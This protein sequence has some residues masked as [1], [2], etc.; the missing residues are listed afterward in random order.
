MN[1]SLRNRNVVVVACC[2]GLLLG[3]ATARADYIDHFATRTDVGLYKVPS[4]GPTR[5]LVL[6][7]FIDDIGYPGGSE[8]A[9]LDEI[10]AFFADGADAIF[11]G[12]F[13]FTPYWEQASLGRFRP[14]AEVAAP[15][16]FPTC[17]PLGAHADCEIPRGAG[18]AEGDIQGAVQVLQDALNF[19]DEI[20]TCA[21]AGPGG[22]SACTAGGGVDF[23]RYDTSGN[24]QGVADGFVDGVI[25]VS[26]A[27]F[28]GIAL[29][30]KDLATNPLLS[31]FGPFPSFTYPDDDGVVVASVGIAGRT[32]RP[33]RE[34][35]VSVHEF[36][37]LLGFC[38]L[39]NES[40]A[41]TDHPYTLMGGWFYADAGS[42]L[43]PFSRVAIGWANVIQVA[44]P[45]QAFAVPSA[46]RSGTVL[47]VGDGD[48][49][50]LVE[51]R[52]RL[53]DV[54]DADMSID[55][56]VLVQRVRLSKRPSP[57]P[58]DY[59]N[60]LQACVNCTP[61]DAMLTVE[62]ADGNYD[63]QLNRG[64]DDDGDLFQSGD[65][66]GPSTD[67]QQR[68][69]NHVVF[70][71]NL[72]SGAPTGL[73][74]TVT[75]SDDDGAVVDVDA[76][77]VADPCAALSAVCPG[78]CVVD[79]DG[80]GRCG[81]FQTFPATPPEDDLPPPVI[82]ACTCANTSGADAGLLAAGLLLLL[83]RRQRAA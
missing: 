71:T 35:F 70:S 43:D 22:G 82:S 2:A 23:A 9:F 1:A 81:D 52:Q 37:H 53:P 3:A 66:I 8:Q 74:I 41:T 27:G 14:A 83:R 72:L 17:P 24:Q 80:H 34:T 6:P 54:L 60:T 47:K 76:P 58:G 15:V 42:L 11:D 50:F 77:A 48:E 57:T 40:G 30:V 67:T 10:T 25:I 68:S 18:L 56:G 33:G 36:G 46:A 59:F 29:P 73:S 26:N 32:T 12:G 69:A 13:R 63:L 64:R 16:H 75:S 28:P 21:H 39:Y 65:A 7:V 20:F 55:S 62:E 61:F 19:M 4:Q 31:F 45:G 38:D 51:H 78:A 79:D 49:F 44:G 5:V